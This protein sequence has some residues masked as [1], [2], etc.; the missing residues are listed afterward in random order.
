MLM[1]RDLVRGEYLLLV[2]A[3]ERSVEEEASASDVR[4]A[5]CRNEERSVGEEALASG[6]A[7]T[8]YAKAGERLIER[9]VL[10]SDV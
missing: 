1:G 9:E 5:W 6:V 3:G 10:V 8:G 7:R 4:W 2:V